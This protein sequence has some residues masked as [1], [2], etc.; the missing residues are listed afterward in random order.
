MEGE[1]SC[2]SICA[3]YRVHTSHCTLYACVIEG[4]A[5]ASLSLPDGQKW[6]GNFSHF[7]QSFLNF[8][9][10]LVRVGGEALTTPLI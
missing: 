3:N 10:V 7:P 8:F 9:L 6:D 1:L 5:I 4:R 2:S